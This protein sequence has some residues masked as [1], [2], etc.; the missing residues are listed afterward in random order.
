MSYFD[1]ASLVLIPSGYKDQKI[2][3]V[4]PLDGAGDLAF[5]RASSATRVASNGLIEKVRTNLILQSEDFTNVA[6]AVNA[7]PTITANTT[8]AP[9]GTTTADT[10]ASTASSSGAYQVPTVVSGVE[11]SFSVYVKNITS[12]TNVQIGCDLGPVNG[13]LNFNAV[14]GAITTTAAGI[15]GSSVT[16][17]GNGWYRVSGTYIATGTTNTFIVFGQSGMTFA[18]W[19]AQL[20]TGVTTDYIA[21][22]SA[23]VSVGPVSGL[24]RLDY[25]NSTCPRLLLEPQRTNLAL[26]SES[27]T[28]SV[29]NVGYTATSNV[30]TSPDGYVNAD[31][32]MEDTS[33]FHLIQK[34]F[35]VASTTDSYAVSFFVKANGRT[36]G[37]II[38]GLDGAPFSAI[39]A[40][41]NLTNGTITAASG[42]GGATAGSSKIENYGNGWYRVSVS[43]VMGTAGTHYVRMY[44]ENGGAAG[45]PTKGF[46]IYGFQAEL[47][48]YATSYIPTL[49]TSVTRV[50]DAAF[51]TSASAL[52]GQ[53]E[54]TLYSEFTINGLDDFGTALCINNGST[55]ESIWLTT[56][57]NGWIR[58]EVYS[59]TAGGVQATFV[60]TGGTVGQ[61]YK[62]AI[63]YA[64]NNFAFFVNGTQVGSTDLLGSVPVGMN[65]IDFDYTNSSIFVKSALAIKQALVLPTRLSNSDLA[66]LTA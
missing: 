49:G 66:A 19:G 37:Q 14:T 7:A 62:I 17:V 48:A 24:P 18:V 41:F 56:F 3:S 2:F 47:G 65:R 9:N 11:Y 54:G 53:T 36:T 27:T 40:T 20:E 55:S 4:K 12:A 28:T 63:G 29:V 51:K 8:V 45:D 10:I 46:F 38:Y 33:T 30:A 25:L 5:S 64:A 31:R 59:N 16:N 52:I 42:S 44:N 23:A 60:K 50:A 1:D 32:I 22:T 34:Q 13:F 39:G 35:S 57:A 15:T 43:G 26:Q 58:A 61:T 21:T 6:W